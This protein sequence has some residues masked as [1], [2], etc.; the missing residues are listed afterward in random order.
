MTK[1]KDRLKPSKL[2][3]LNIPQNPNQRGAAKTKGTTLDRHNEDLAMFELLLHPTKGFRRMTARRIR[4]ATLTAELK[5]GA[6]SLPLSQIQADLK[7]AA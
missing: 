6:I 5:S 4:A 7:L 3:L 2:G 1:L